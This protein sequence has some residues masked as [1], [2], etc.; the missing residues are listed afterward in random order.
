MQAYDTVATT[1]AGDGL[2][3]EVAMSSIHIIYN[4]IRIG[5]ADCNIR[6]RRN[7]NGD[8]VIITVVNSLRFRFTLKADM[9]TVRSFNTLNNID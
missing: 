7:G 9:H 4:N 8:S 1:A 6:A 3:D 2:Q 5:R